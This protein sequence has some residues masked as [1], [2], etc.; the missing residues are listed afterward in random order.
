[1]RCFLS[2]FAAAILWITASGAVQAADFGTP[3]GPALL[4]ARVGAAGGTAVRF[5]LDMLKKLGV[6]TVT[7][8]TPWTDDATVF[9]AVPGKALLAAL[10]VRDGVLIAK[11]VN[12]YKVEIPVEDLRD[13]GAFIAFSMNGK[14]LT[15]R[16]K[17]P[18]WLLYPFSD[19]AELDNPVYYNRAIW[20]LTHL[21]IR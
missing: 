8:K 6:V 4:E 17:G 21:E 19:K 3:T 18:L 2:V 9:E 16:D 20:Q 15:V 13:K 5:D 10:G 11:A 14:R 12:D 7:T 1:M